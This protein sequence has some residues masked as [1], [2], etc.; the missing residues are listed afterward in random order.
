A[1]RLVTQVGEKLHR[2]VTVA[3][4]FNL[5]TPALLATA[6]TGPESTRGGIFTT[7]R[8]EVLPLSSSQQRMWFSNQVDRRGYTVPVRLRL[9]GV[10]HRRALEEALD[11]VIARH[12]ILR[13][14]YPHTGGLPRQEILPAAAGLVEL[15]HR[16]V[17]AAELDE[18]VAVRAGS[19]FDLTTELPLKA[20]LFTAGDAG[21]ESGVDGAEG[22]G[23][24]VL[25]LLLHHIAT[26]ELSSGPLMN[27]LSLAYTAR[28]EG[29]QVS[30]EPLPVQYADYA[31]WQAALL[32][33]E[34]LDEEMARG[35]AYWKQTLTG[36]PEKIAL[37]VDS[38]YPATP[39]P[40]AGAVDFL[41]P[42]ETHRALAAL[43]TRNSATL[44]MVMQAALAGVLSRHGAGDDIPIATPVAGRYDEALDD[45]IGCFINT[46][47]LRTPTHAGMTFTEALR[48]AREVMLGALAHQDVPFEWVVKELRP[49][50]SHSQTASFQVLLSLLHS[51]PDDVQLPGLAVAEEGGMQELTPGDLSLHLIA[52]GGQQGD[53]GDI[54]GHLSFRLDLFDEVSVRGLVDRFVRFLECVAVDPGVL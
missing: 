17:P 6:I 22:A 4:L 43:A 34:K 18:S 54:R 7:P 32:D 48:A 24:H 29:R 28:C 35:L 11:D 5:P 52:T 31:V 45:L 10:L 26:D 19:A 13:T 3:D 8:P 30:W 27:D 12:E 16:T 36:M 40:Q 20:S 23:E 9:T 44:F 41:I 49:N 39:S 38:P 33:P 1:V 42:A 37:P 50:R 53:P 14:F 21:A 46:I 15:E 47:C 2:P 25:L 51:L